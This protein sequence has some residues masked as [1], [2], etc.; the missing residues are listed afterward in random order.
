MKACFSVGN[1]DS[2]FELLI[3]VNEFLDHKTKGS[4]S[5]GWLG[6]AGMSLENQ[7]NKRGG[8]SFSAQTVTCSQTSDRRWILFC[9]MQSG[10]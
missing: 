10:P 6:N 4:K 9:Y 8:L 1:I 3:L 7:E 5:Y 2:F